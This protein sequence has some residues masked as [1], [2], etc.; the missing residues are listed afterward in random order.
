LFR[1]HP[2]RDTKILIYEAGLLRCRWYQPCAQ[3]D[4][5]FTLGF[6]RSTQIHLRTRPA[7]HGIS[8]MGFGTAFKFES[9]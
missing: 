9:Q 1:L 2:K 6:P 5:T 3:S 7:V 8:R 4:S